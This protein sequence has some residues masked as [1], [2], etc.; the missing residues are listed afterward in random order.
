VAKSVRKVINRAPFKKLLS[1]RSKKKIIELNQTET[2]V[3]VWNEKIIFEGISGE[4]SL[5]EKDQEKLL[6]LKCII[7]ADEVTPFF[8]SGQKFCISFRHGIHYFFG[9]VIF[10]SATKDSILFEVFGKQLYKFERRKRDRLR[11]FPHKHIKL[12]MQHQDLKI[13]QSN[14]APNNENVAFDKADNVI[15]LGRA[16]ILRNSSAGNLSESQAFSLWDLGG[17]GFSIL[18]DEENMSFFERA[19]ESQEIFKNIELAYDVVNLSLTG[20]QVLHTREQVAQLNPS[21]KYKNQTTSSKK[22]RVGMVIN[23]PH[24]NPLEWFLKLE[25]EPYVPEEER[26]LFQKF[27]VNLEK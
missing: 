22:I 15:S 16:R 14:S 25:N 21:I 7:L 19:K 24:E 17:N 5:P 1:P 13:N 4:G 2:S 26:V 12:K 18:V 10:Q 23:N 11:V 6:K 9:Q 27:V 8:A 3:L 20:V